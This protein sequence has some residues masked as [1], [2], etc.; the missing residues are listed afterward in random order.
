MDPQPL[1]CTPP[2][3]TLAAF[4]PNALPN[5]CVHFPP[6]QFQIFAGLFLLLHLAYVSHM[7][8]QAA[9][10]ARPACADG[11]GDGGGDNGGDSG[12]DGEERRYREI[13]SR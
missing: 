2:T 12:S 9:A 11:G 13:S 3:V 6:L 5:A 7:L 8:Y 4:P 10:R 1:F